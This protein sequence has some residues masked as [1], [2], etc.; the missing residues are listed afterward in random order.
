MFVFNNFCVKLVNEGYN[1]NIGF[2]SLQ[3]DRRFLMSMHFNTK[4][5]LIFVLCVV[6]IE[7]SSILNYYGNVKVKGDSDFPGAKRSESAIHYFFLSFIEK[8]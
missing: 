1:A 6:Y 3:Q 7:I 8:S 4:V 2:H 5:I